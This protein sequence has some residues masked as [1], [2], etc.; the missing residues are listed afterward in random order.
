[1]SLL[2]SAAS[3]E[4]LLLDLRGVISFKFSLS[5]SIRLK[6]SILALVIQRSRRRR[7][8]SDR[9]TFAVLRMGGMPNRARCTHIS[10]WF[11]NFFGS[12]NG[13]GSSIM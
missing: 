8:S 5:G 11:S 9:P 13:S 10:S 3:F 4:R 7:S 2:D 1:M 12:F 6:L